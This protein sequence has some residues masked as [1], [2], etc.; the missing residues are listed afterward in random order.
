MQIG[1]YDGLASRTRVPTAQKLRLTL[2]FASDSQPSPSLV[3]YAS[4]R[5]VV[6]SLAFGY[7]RVLGFAKE[8]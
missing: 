7:L 2:G 3:G 1:P 4:G 5:G 8:R 6:R